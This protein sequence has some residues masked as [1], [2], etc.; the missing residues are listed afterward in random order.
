MLTALPLPDRIHGPGPR[1]RQGEDSI[2]RQH[3]LSKASRNLQFS[4]SIHLEYA[5]LPAIIQLLAKYIDA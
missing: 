5:A 2:V 4:T 3:S 1:Q